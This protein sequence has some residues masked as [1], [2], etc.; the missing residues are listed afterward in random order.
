MFVEA[1]AAPAPHF[2]PSVHA[3]YPAWRDLFVSPR[4]LLTVSRRDLSFYL[5]RKGHRAS[6]GWQRPNGVLFV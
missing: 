4:F 1:E 5:S 6:F 2:S 3:V